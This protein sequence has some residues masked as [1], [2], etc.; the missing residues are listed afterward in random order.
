MDE[1]LEARRETIW[2]LKKTLAVV[3]AGGRGTRLHEL[4]EEQSKP[5]LPFAGKFRIVDFPL[6]NCVNSG[7]RRIGVVTQ[8]RAHTL[9]IH[10]Q[11]GWRLLRHELNEFVE[12]WPAQ[13][14]TSEESW[15]RGTADAIY[16]N[17]KIIQD[18][19]PEYVL[20]LGG[21]HVYKQDYGILVRE[22][23][24][25]GADV[26]VAC[27]AVPKV[28]ARSFGVA[29]A[30]A[31]GRIRD[32]V[33]KPADPPSIPGRPDLAF[34]S[35]GIYVFTARYLFDELAR[36]ARDPSSTH[37][38]GRDLIPRAVKH[39][40]AAAH[41]F[42]ASCIP[43]RGTKETYWRDVGTLDAYWEANLDLTKVTPALDMYDLGWPIWTYQPQR[44]AAKFVFDDNWRRGMAVDSVVSSGCIVSGGLVRR[45]LLFSDVRVNS[46][47]LVEDSVILPGSDVGRH[48][49]IRKAIVDE[50][51]RLGERLVVGEDA[52]ADARRFRRTESGV[53]LVTAKMLSKL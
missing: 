12:V 38:F 13:Q 45:S 2:P 3:L 10:L 46:F 27:V 51:C 4:T 8:Y 19:A 39:G 50:G 18:H 40:R 30:E 53:T 44:P 26:T 33:E 17:L 16:Q 24:E 21:D 31:D 23:I 48:C 43:N 34:A 9:L 11:R 35:M 14:Q 36:D 37:D 41:D 15:Y 32:F 1:T 28:Q 20:V 22:H 47:S 6:S 25:R 7:I 49:R 5:A 29:I 42:A 52:A